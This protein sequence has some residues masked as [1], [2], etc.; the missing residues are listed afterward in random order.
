VSKGV[1]GSRLQAAG[2][3]ESKPIADNRT[4]AGRAQNRRVVLRRTDISQ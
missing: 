4:E 1:A 3:G 2:L